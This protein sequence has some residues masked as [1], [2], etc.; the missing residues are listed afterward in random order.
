MVL[1]FGSSTT[2]GNLRYDTH[3]THLRIRQGLA[4]RAGSARV[5]LPPS[6]RVDAAAGD[7]V[8]VLVDAEETEVATFGGVVQRIERSVDRTTIV[9]GDALARL[10]WARP[11]ATFEQQSAGAVIRALA[12][13]ADVPAG[14]IEDGPA[15][16]V[17]VADQGR[18]ALEHVGLLSSWSGAYAISDAEGSLLVPAVPTGRA[19]LALRFGREIE[20]LHVRAVSPSPDVVWIGSGPAGSAS[21]PNAHLQTTEVLPDSA[22]DPGP[23]TIRIP[24]PS[25]RTPSAAT[26]ATLAT[27]TRNPSRRLSAT[28]WLQPGIRPGALIEVADAPQPESSGPWFVTDVVH[29]IGPGPRGVTR[30]EADAL[31]DGGSLLGDLLGAIGS[32]L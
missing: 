23:R 28:C 16:V 15:L 21:A 32:L 8:S 10:A 2:V 12:T 14:S 25:L 11:G 1:S 27:A 26:D 30:L 19:D 29:E 20:S 5:M 9:A 6:V 7:D 31:G 4:P 18:T 3:S 17:Y 13:A 24:G 22:P